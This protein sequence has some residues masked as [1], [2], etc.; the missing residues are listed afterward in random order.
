MT[1]AW[2]WAR[3]EL[4][5]RWR[6]WVVLGLLAGAT[7]GLVA[8]GIAGARR[9]DSSLP[10]YIAAVGTIDAAVLANDPAFDAKQR[11][12]IAA[13][14]EV[15][16]TFPFSVA[17]LANVSKPRGLPTA[18]AGNGAPERARHRRRPSHQPEEP[19]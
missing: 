19:R 17:V 16:K 5:A 14:P 2:F 11:A 18:D 4:R 3:A 13:L 15:R 12:A 1:A 9:T 6:S 8:A 7:A 10:R